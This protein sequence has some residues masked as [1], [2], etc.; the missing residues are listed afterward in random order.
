MIFKPIES[1][2]KNIAAGL[3]LAL[4]RKVDQS[5]FS[6]SFLQLIL[7]VCSYIAIGFSTSLFEPHNNLTQQNLMLFE[8]F[9]FNVLVLLLW[10]LV[11]LILG[12]GRLLEFLIVVYA[13]AFLM[14][15]AQ[16]ILVGLG[17]WEQSSAWYFMPVLIFT[18]LV[19]L[20][21]LYVLYRSIRFSV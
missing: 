6:I 8:L 14:E 7:F 17:R 16:I 5:Y 1:F 12:K 13:S 10:G 3:G 2:L 19:L 11:G 21:S 18:F 15:F 20:W 9:M 4:G